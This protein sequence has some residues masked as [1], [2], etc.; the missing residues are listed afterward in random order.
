MDIPGKNRNILFASVGVAL[1]LCGAQIVG[2]TIM[3]LGGL[4]LYMILLVWCCWNDYTFPVLLFFLP[5]SPIMRLSLSGFSVYTIGLVLICLI[6]TFKNHFS[7]RVYQIKAG[8]MIMVL[9]LVS[10]LLDGSSLSFDYVAFLMMMI[11]FPT[12]MQEHE[13]RT[14]NFYHC[15]IFFSLGIIIAA[16]CAMFFEEYAN[17]R[18]FVRVDSYLTIV[19]RSGFYNDPNFYVAQILAALSG[20]LALILQE[21]KGKKLVFLGTVALFLLYCGFLSGSKSFILTSALILLLWVGAI[22]KMR[23]RT[24]A[25]VALLAFLTCTVIFIATSAMFGDLIEVIMTRFSY[26]NNM[27]SF[28]T[29]RTQLWKNYIYEILSNIKV[30]FMGKG[31]TNLKVNGRASHNTIIQIFYQFGILGVPVIVYWIG[32]F[33]QEMQNINNQRTRFDIKLFIVGIGTFL[34][35]LAIDA[36]FFDEFFLFQMYMCL[37]INWFGQSSL[38]IKEKDFRFNMEEAY[39]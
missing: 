24:G 2:S 3:V 14:Y 26:A 20:I 5:W 12:V 32:C 37:A 13:K 7:F 6:S 11:L 27:D 16:L 34:P 10:K 22:I 28:T 29:G 36:L 18:K 1:L 8:L 19:R 39:E 9:S 38:S 30:F 25:K 17:I 4:A 35:W 31:F 33:F 15:V 23:G 21:K